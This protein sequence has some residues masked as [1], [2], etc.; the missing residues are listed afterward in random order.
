MR[1]TINVENRY[2]ADLIA[3]AIEDPTVKAAVLVTGMLL[4]LPTVPARREVLSFALSTVAG[5][6]S[7]PRPP[8]PLRLHDATGTS[9]D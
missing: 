3:R 1:V 4:D 9:G 2:E 7:G 5:Q 6:E 8:S